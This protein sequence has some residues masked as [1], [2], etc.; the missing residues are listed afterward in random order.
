MSETT[1]GTFGITG[2]KE[3]L[4]HLSEALVEQL[5]PPFLDAL[6][7]ESVGLFRGLQKIRTVSFE[8]LNGESLGAPAE[9]EEAG[10]S[11]FRLLMRPILP[12]IH[13]T[14]KVPSHLAILPVFVA[15]SPLGKVL[16]TELKSLL[17]SCEVCIESKLLSEAHEAVERMGAEIEKR[18]A[19]IE[20]QIVQAIKG[21]RLPKGIDGQWHIT[22]I[23]AA[24][25]GR[26]IETL[27]EIERKLGRIRSWLIPLSHAP[28][29]PPHA[30]ERIELSGSSDRGASDEAKL[31]SF[32]EAEAD[33]PGTSDFAKDC[34]TR[35]CPV[36]NRLIDAANR[37]FATWQ[38]ALATQDRAQHEYAASLG[39]C[40]LHTWQLAATASPRGLSQGYPA[41]MERL[42]ADL[43]REAASE[44]TEAERLVLSLGQGSRHCRVCQRLSEVEAE[45]LEG[46]ASFVQTREGQTA[47]IYSQGVCLH[48]LGGLI[49]LIP[50]QEVRRSL[51]EHAARRFAEI[52]VDMKNCALK[53]DALSGHVPSQDEADAYLRG[54][55]HSVGARRVCF[56][57]ELDAEI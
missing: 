34:T 50:S 7:Q 54:L 27:A 25:L 12:K 47:Y 8:T 32:Q 20:S 57:W 13:W 43:S 16:A 33:I 45:Y 36:C 2:I 9:T 5:N 31:S 21:R 44:E 17:R 37:F 19:E 28:S 42:S 29:E 6:R 23:D 1:P 48:H 22:Q 49:G 14:P 55:I 15:R 51:L 30:T 26:E 52:S 56:P 4:E 24:E 18:A 3:N 41:F 46:L 10:V 11:D 38:H 40:P 35:G 53:R 39:F